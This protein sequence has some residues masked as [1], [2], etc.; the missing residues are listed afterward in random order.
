[1]TE[2]KEYLAWLFEEVYIKDIVERYPIERKEVLEDILDLLSSSISSLTNPTK[3]KNIL[4]SVKHINVSVN[5][6][7]EYLDYIQDSFLVSEARRYDIKGKRY[8]NYPNKYYY[9][10]LGL[11]NARLNFRQFD[12]GHILE[13]IIYN[14]LLIRGYSVDVGVVIDRRNSANIQK[15][16][17]F[18]VNYG[19]KRLYIQSAYEMQTIEKMAAESDSLKLAKDFFKKVIVQKDIPESYFD[20]EG[21][22]H[23]NVFNF[24]LGDQLF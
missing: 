24:L 9:T 13:N 17:D 3:I 12:Q 22:F 18:V 20:E 10:D 6:V 15:E 11:R 21:I 16:I 4:S 2:K 1:M 8:F 5:T 23:I 19:D 7:G 14:E